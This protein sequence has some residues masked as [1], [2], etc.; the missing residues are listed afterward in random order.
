[1]VAQMIGCNTLL[2][3]GVL[4]IGV[5]HLSAIGRLLPLAR[6]CFG[7]IAVTPGMQ[8]T[9]HALSGQEASTFHPQAI[10]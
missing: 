3:C 4:S 5:T 8:L 9:T 1:M 2:F 7:S 10:L 6:V